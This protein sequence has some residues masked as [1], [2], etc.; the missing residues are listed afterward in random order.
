MKTVYN[1][2]VVKI[3]ETRRDYDFIAVVENKIDR[4]IQLT[5]KDENLEDEALVL[6]EGDWCGILAD[7]DGYFKLKELKNGRFSV[8]MCQ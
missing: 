7:S 3:S 2:G 6:S 4:K 1:D 5:F 8:K